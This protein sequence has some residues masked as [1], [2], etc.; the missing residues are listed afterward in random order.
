MKIIRI[1]KRWSISSKVHH[2]VLTDDN[3]SLDNI[4]TA[5]ED[6]FENDPSGRYYHCTYGW[7]FEDDKAVIETVLKNK[8][9][10][11]ENELVS[12][13]SDKEK[14]NFFLSK[15]NSTETANYYQNLKELNQKQEE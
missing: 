11:I 9:D 4:I 14:I 12:L 3:Y 1:T 6:W 15:F 7:Y 8:L 10:E 2:L 13:N 5:I